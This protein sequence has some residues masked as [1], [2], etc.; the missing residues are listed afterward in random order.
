MI[1]LAMEKNVSAASFGSS[2]AEGKN[3]ESSVGSSL[4][5]WELESAANSFKNP[6]IYLLVEPMIKCTGDLQSLR[7]LN[8]CRFLQFERVYNVKLPW[9]TM[10][11]G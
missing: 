7:N 10:L 2:S 6:K 3:L 1:L 5:D 9:K 4:Q 11:G 8:L